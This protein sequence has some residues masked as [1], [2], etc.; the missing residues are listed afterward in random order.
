M[1]RASWVVLGALV[2]IGCATPYGKGELDPERGYVA[3]ELPLTVR[4]EGLDALD[5][6]WMI[7]SHMPSGSPRGGRQLMTIRTIDTNDDGRR[8][9]YWAYDFHLRL[10]QRTGGGEMWVESHILEPVEQTRELRVLADEV[11]AA[12]AE[13][14]R[15]NVV[16]WSENGRPVLQLRPVREPIQIDI[17]DRMDGILDGRDAHLVVFRGTREGTGGQVALLFTRAPFYHLEDGSFGRIRG[18][19]VLVVAGYG[20]G[21]SDFAAG[22]DDFDRLLRAIEMESNAAAL[23]ID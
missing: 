14:R 16:R 19:P 10:A 21:P 18:W 11:L 2:T 15:Q 7:T 12:I 1:M 20:N 3:E 13:G 8:E 4:A 23:G 5:G 17:L 6:R 22:L 9:R